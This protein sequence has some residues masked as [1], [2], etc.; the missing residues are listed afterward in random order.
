MP[1][2]NQRIKSAINYLDGIVTQGFYMSI[3]SSQ[4]KSFNA[5]LARKKLGDK[6][7]Q[8]ALEY[9]EKKNMKLLDKNWR[10]KHGEIDLVMMDGETLCFVEVRSKIGTDRGHPLETITAAKQR[11]IVRVSSHYLQINNLEESP[12]RFDAVGIVKDGEK[13]EITHIPA[14]FDAWML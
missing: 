8:I 14:A 12:V 13:F 7:E 11:Q 5:S 4:K 10:S 9:L 1:V 3:N 2:F 6:G